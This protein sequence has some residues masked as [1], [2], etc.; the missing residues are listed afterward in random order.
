MS[1][2]AQ[3]VTLTAAP[4]KE[5][6]LQLA[7][8]KLAEATRT[9]F[10]CVAY[11]IYQLDAATFHVIELWRDAVSLEFHVA[12]PHTSAVLESFPSLLG[13][14]PVLTPAE[15]ISVSALG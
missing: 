14:A 15:A 1:T 8:A 10:G 12:A 11:D 6:A 13:A 4:G 9:E 2:I 5:Q 7:L 3:F